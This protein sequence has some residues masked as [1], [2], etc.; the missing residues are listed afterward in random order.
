MGQTQQQIPSLRQ[1]PDVGCN[2]SRNSKNSKSLIK[3]KQK[4]DLFLMQCKQNYLDGIFPG[5]DAI[6]QSKEYL[7]LKDIAQSY[8]NE[9]QYEDFEGFFMEDKYLIQLWAAHL[10]LEYG[11][12]TDNLKQKCLKEIEKYSQSTLSPKVATQEANWLERYVNRN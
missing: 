8:F 9:D 2:A 11:N 1:A 3:L 7:I 10:I 4:S 5:D 6:K 12:P